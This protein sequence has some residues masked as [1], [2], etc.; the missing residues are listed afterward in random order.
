[1]YSKEIFKTDEGFG[2]KILKN[3][4]VFIVQDFKP[5]VEGWIPMT[6][7]EANQ[8]ADEEIKNLVALENNQ[9]I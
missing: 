9:K 3:E 5:G 1:M 7:E 6:K 8:L 2:Y 4:V